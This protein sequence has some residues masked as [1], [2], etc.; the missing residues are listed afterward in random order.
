[1]Y[2]IHFIWKDK[3]RTLCSRG[4]DM[5]HPYFVSLEELIFPEASTVIIGPNDDEM[6]REFGDA[7]TIMIPFQNVSLIETLHDT[8]ETGPGKVISFPPTEEEE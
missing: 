4:L 6:R 7:R 5:T 8:T 1:M 2:R 3:P